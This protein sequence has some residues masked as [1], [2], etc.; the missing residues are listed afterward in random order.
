M[1]HRGSLIT[2]TMPEAQR[3]VQ[4]LSQQGKL[5]GTKLEELGRWD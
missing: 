2:T 4:G 1:R 3:S 5:E